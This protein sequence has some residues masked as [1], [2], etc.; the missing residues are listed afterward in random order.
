[1]VLF[2]G[3]SDDLDLNEWLT[4]YIFPAEA[5]NVDE[6]FVRAG[7]RLGLGRDDP[8]RYDDV[9]RHVLLR[10]CDRRRN[11]KGRVRGVLGETII[12][13]P[14]PDNKTWA[15]GAGLHRAVHQ[16]M[17]ER[18]ADRR[19]RSLRTRLTRS[20]RNICSRPATLSDKTKGT[21]RHPLGG[22]EHRDRVHS[23]KNIRASGR[24]SLSRRSAFSTTGRSP[25]MSFTRTM[26][27]S[28]C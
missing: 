2:R 6:A 13:F 17:E 28:T 22:G 1:M 14:A 10:G 23:A 4:K 24:S 26:P 8:R 7:T 20:R 12:D 21:A 5:K 27:R 15:A 11:E 16:Q 18:S 25:L 3:I 19:R 9:L